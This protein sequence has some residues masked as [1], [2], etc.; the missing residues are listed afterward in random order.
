MGEARR[1][2]AAARGADL[3]RMIRARARTAVERPLSPVTT[4]RGM[5]PS[6]GRVIL[7]GRTDL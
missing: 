2:T 4:P 3:K 5:A 6:A 1:P 7:E